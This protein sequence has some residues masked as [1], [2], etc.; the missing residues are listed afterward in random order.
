[1]SGLSV[2]R[3][4]SKVGNSTLGAGL[5][6][7][8]A[9]KLIS[10]IDIGSIEVSFPD[11]EKLAHVGREPGP[12]ADIKFIRWRGLRRLLTQGDIGL[13]QGYL[14]GDWISRDVV[15][16][17]ELGARCGSKLTDQLAGSIPFRLVNWVAHLRNANTR[18][19]SRRNIMAHYDLGNEFYRLWLDRSMMYSSAIY[20]R[21]GETLEEAQS[22]KLDRIVDVLGVSHA[23]E[24]LEIG[25]GWGGLAARLARAGAQRITSVTISPSQLEEARAMVEREDLSGRVEFR[26]Q[27]YRDIS[28]RFD[29]VVSIEM[30]E[31]VGKT[32]LPKYFETIRDR[33]KPG[34]LCVLQAIT[35]AESAFGDYCRR[36]DFIQRYVFPGGF[37]PSKTFLRDTAEKAGLRLVGSEA[38]GDSYA[39]TLR[40]WRRRFHEAW[41]QI[42][43]L[44]FDIPFRRLWDYYLS[45]C[46]AGFRAGMIDVG[47]YS[48][49]R[50]F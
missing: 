7:L 11:G 15:A 30:I 48:I 27:D 38:F 36:P 23:A 26:L 1:M 49:E 3:K 28:G 39:L 2:R 18:G 25:S 24:V 40:E 6:R 8:V 21:P 20:G 42:E 35:I 12:A 47:L 9:R 34:G 46:E 19:G 37:L 5:G 17:I 33:L 13:A 16:L 45:Y 22:R 43:R 50:P 29:R 32:Y 41:P 10:R 4:A 44:G 14:D 31:A